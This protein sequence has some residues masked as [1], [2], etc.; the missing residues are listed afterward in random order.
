M[1]LKFF[2]VPE[3]ELTF[4]KTFLSCP[5]YFKD[6]SSSAARIRQRGVPISYMLSTLFGELSMFIMDFGV[7]Q[8]A[9]G[10]FLYR[11]HDD[12]WLWHS[13]C[14]MCVSA[15]EEMQKYADLAGL[16]F[17]AEK[18]GSIQIG[19]VSTHE[20]VEVVTRGKA[21]GL[22]KGDIRWGF[23]L[24]DNSGRFTIDQV[25]VD[26]HID[27]MRRQLAA[28]TSVFGWVQA[29]NKY[30]S[31]IVRNCGQ[32]ALVYGKAHIDDIIDTLART[33][34]ELFPPKSKGELAEGSSS[35]ITEVAKMLRSKFGT[36]TSKM[37]MGWYLWPNAAG[38]LEMK[39]PLADLFVMRNG[40]GRSPTKIIEE[41][42]KAERQQYDQ[43]KDLWESGPE[44]DYYRRDYCRIASVQPTDPFFPFEEFVKARTERATG[45]LNAY[46]QLLQQPKLCPV[47]CTPQISASLTLF[48][49]PQF[50]RGL[51]AFASQGGSSDGIDSDKEEGEEEEEEEEKEK[52][53]EEEE[54]DV[55]IQGHSGNRVVYTSKYWSK[56]SPYWQSIIGLHHNE[57]VNM[58]GS[59][60]I[61]DPG[62]IPVGMVDA[63]KGA[64]VRWE[65]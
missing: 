27:E 35:A 39:D 12:F 58:F 38:G 24:M 60:A 49:H 29:Y 47:S 6:D 30:M 7:N 17:N 14:K 22:P 2:G 43:A 28:T 61:V 1:I 53:E 4:F 8:K 41:A 63:F 45:W 62:T 13:E 5:I 59:L 50:G 57:M 33:Q 10:L 15:W 55:S 46:Q 16:S 37:P 42:F 56:V 52:E 36:D 31:F 19:D 54:E 32:P 44:L 26:T 40:Y 21:D 65:L 18:T 11:L 64:R 9:E 25:M 34:R 51:E 23:L 48:G 3:R 20:F